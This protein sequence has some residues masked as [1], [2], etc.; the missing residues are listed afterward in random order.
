MKKDSYE[1][2]RI[3]ALKYS[4]M[5]DPTDCNIVIELIFPYTI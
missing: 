4:K 3:S 5:L 2:S 1:A